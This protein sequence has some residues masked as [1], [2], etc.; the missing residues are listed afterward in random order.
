MNSFYNEE[1]LKGLGLKRYGENVLISRNAT[2]YG[3]DNIEIGSNVRIDDFCV[4]SGRIVFGNNVH[5]A[6]GVYMFAGEYGIIL[7][8]YSGISS[9]TALYATNDD[10]SGEYMTN[11]TVSSEYRKVT[12]GTI[13]IGK[14]SLIGTGCT[15]LPGVKVN[16]GASVGAMS[17]INKD[18]EPFT[19]NIGIPCKKIKDRSKRLL[20]LEQKYNQKVKTI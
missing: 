15:I 6:T 8:D 10:Y 3:A 20:E 7:N 9:R 13:Y 16:D 11:P 4:L 1:E 2:I 19:M 18:I 17:L 14:H 12:G 5:I